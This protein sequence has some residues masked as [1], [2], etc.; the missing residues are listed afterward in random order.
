MKLPTK[1]HGL[2][3]DLTDADHCAAC[4]GEIVRQHRKKDEKTL[5]Q[6]SSELGISIAALAHME[7][8][9]R[10]M[11]WNRFQEFARIVRVPE[12]KQ[13]EVAALTV[14]AQRRTLFP[15]HHDDLEK[16]RFTAKL[17]QRWDSLLMRDFDRLYRALD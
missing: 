17:V 11:P 13:L 14:L 5:R 7:R 2:P 6:V 3:V 1:I 9:I 4:V 10:L 12:T 15:V 16:L 8:G